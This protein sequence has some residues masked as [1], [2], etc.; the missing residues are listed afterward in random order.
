MGWQTRAA[1]RRVGSG[2][3]VRRTLTQSNTS[4]QAVAFMPVR[5]RVCASASSAARWNSASPLLS[6]TAA[7]TARPLPSSAKPTSAQPLRA[8]LRACAG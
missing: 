2:Y 1:R 8:S 3:I 6:S 4:R 7:P 5:N